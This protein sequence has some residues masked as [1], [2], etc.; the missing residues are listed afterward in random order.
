M[1]DLQNLQNLQ[2]FFVQNSSMISMKFYKFYKFYKYLCK[3]H[4]VESQMNIHHM[5]IFIY[6]LR[7]KLQNLQTYRTF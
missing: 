7:K 1:T 6:S 2:N 4:Q 5:Y 3:V